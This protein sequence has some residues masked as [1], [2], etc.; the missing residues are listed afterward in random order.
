M[1][2]DV[3]SSEI[4]TSLVSSPRISFSHYLNNTNTV[5][6]VPPLFDFHFDFNFCIGNNFTHLSSA[7]DIFSNGKILPV[8]IKKHVTPPN[9][10]EATSAFENANEGT[11]KKK[12]KEFLCSEFD[13]EEDPKPLPKSF[14]K[15]S[16]SSS[17]NVESFR[18]KALLRSLQFLSRSNSTG[19]SLNLKQTK[20]NQKQNSSKQ[21]PVVAL[22]SRSLPYS[23]GHGY[24]YASPKRS[25]VMKNLR[26]NSNGVGVRFSP[27]LNI[28]YSCIGI[29]KGS[30]TSLF[31]FG[32][33][34][35]NG[36][37]KKK[38]K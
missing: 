4:P 29:D 35:C 31:G 20:N 17:L 26:S 25:P 10:C 34:F 32:S 21:S 30:V 27:V 11:K 36:K 2:V 8:E 9:E 33:L 15:Y 1:A 16:R 5:P 22:N 23:S 24:P 6:T 14:W 38:K 18:S 7:D 12:L 3:C 13:A 37:A 19:S 28:P